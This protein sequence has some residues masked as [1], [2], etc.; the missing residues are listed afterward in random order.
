[1]IPLLGKYF[2]FDDL[3]PQDRVVCTVLDYIGLGFLLV[4]SEILFV[5]GAPWWKWLLSVAVGIFFV[6]MA[7]YWPRVRPRLGPVFVAS[8]TRVANNFWL[9]R[10]AVVTIFGCLI[11]SVLY[12]AFQLRKD[13]DMYVMPRTITAQQAK[14]L[15][16]FLSRYPSFSVGVKVA[17]PSDEESSEYAGEL[18]GALRNTKLDVNPPNHDGPAPMR[19]PK[20]MPKPHRDDIDQFGKPLYADDNIF[21]AAQDR[22]LDSEIQWN[23]DSR[24]YPSRGLTTMYTSVGPAINPDPLHPSSV[25]ILHDALAYAGIKVDGSVSGFGKLEE[26]YLLVGLRPEKLGDEEPM[27]M[28][29]G[30]A[31]ERIG[32]K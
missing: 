24:F 8:I 10:I 28:K 29:I 7:H 18:F 14:R 27:L 3:P 15:S 32:A 13:L 5:S 26:V 23:I 4:V 25:S 20:Y 17:Y 9:R 31:I 30:R 2:M 1:M 16:E 12:F 21:A 22:W 6:W 19:F 11:T